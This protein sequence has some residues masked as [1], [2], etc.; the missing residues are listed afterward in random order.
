MEHPYLNKNFHGRFST[1]RVSELR[2]LEMDSR[3]VFPFA[4]AEVVFECLHDD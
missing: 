1:D 2:G 4:P 3:R